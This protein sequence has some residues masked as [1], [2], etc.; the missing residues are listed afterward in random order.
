MN[1][2]ISAFLQISGWTIFF[3]ASSFGL[4]LLDQRAGPT[5]APAMNSMAMSDTPVHFKPKLSAYTDNYEFLVKMSGLPSPIPYQK[6]FTLHF[7]VYD[8]QHPDKQLSDA[9]LTLLAGMRHNLKHGFAHGMQTAP[10]IGNKAG[11][12][13][14]EGMYFHM[15]GKW[16]LKVTVNE[17]DKQGAAY[18]DLPCCDK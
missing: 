17:G 7:A 12:L 5:P 8:G 18:F 1:T 13:T 11:D 14:V 2:K 10:K 6:Y 9:H 3:V 15:M 16:T 4:Y